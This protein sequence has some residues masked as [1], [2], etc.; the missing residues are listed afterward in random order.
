MNVPFGG[1]ERLS[2]ALG[3]LDRHEPEGV[4][5]QSVSGDSI[6]TPMFS[7]ADIHT[8]GIRANMDLW[9]SYF[10]YSLQTTFFPA[11]VPLAEYTTNPVLRSD[12]S[13]RIQS[14]MGL[15]YENEI[16]EGN[17]RISAG[18]RV[19]YMNMLSPSLTYDQF[20][21]YYLYR[22]LEPRGTGV[23]DDPRL[24]QPKYI[25][26]VLIST[27]IDQRATVNASFLN[28]TSTPY[29][30]VGIY[31]RGGFQFKLDVTWAFLD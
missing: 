30:N 27:V 2:L 8:R 21:D 15:F 1:R 22:G 16:A 23:L 6:V 18:L 19:R 5:L 24:T 25:F 13:Q 9:F 11:T 10:R 26:D 29:Y 31:P 7:S 4:S 17:L 28:L 12:L 14:A 20:S 3:Y